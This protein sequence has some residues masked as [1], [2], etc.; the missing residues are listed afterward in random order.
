MSGNVL[1]DEIRG[2]EEIAASSNGVAGGWIS[3]DAKDQ[4]NRERI[5]HPGCGIWDCAILAESSHNSTDKEEP[6]AHQCGANN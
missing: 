3:D 2:N 5:I 4:L 6:E 1:W